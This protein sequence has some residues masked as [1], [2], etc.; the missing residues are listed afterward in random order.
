MS[1]ISRLEFAIDRIRG[2]RVFTE[3]FLED[4]TDTEWFW[5]P[6]QYATHTAWQVGHLAVA[7]YNLCLRRV[8]GRTTADESLL[9]SDAC[10]EAFKLGSKPVAEPEKNPPLDE[11]RRVF[12]A[13]HQQSV[14]ELSG[15][16]DAELDEP[17]AE[18]HPRFKTKLEAVEFCPLHE[19]VHAGQIAMLRRLMGRP[20]LR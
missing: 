4:L 18:P 3:Q 8:R 14:A 1:S 19:M 5:S 12:N 16:T 20:P 7:Q 13:V 6:P 11:I 15:R 17:L 10:I 2:S 9:V